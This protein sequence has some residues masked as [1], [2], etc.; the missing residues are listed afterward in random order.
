VSSKRKLRVAF[1][2][3]RR[4]SKSLKRENETSNKQKQNIVKDD[5][6][7]EVQGVSRA[8]VHVCEG[9]GK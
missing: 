7:A 2:E 8:R 5:S 9:E 3:V 4:K 6:A 1:E